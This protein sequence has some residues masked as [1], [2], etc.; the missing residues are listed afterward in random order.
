MKVKK[1]DTVVVITGKDAKKTGKVLVSMPKLNKIIVEGVNVQEKNRKARSAQETSQKIKKEGPIDASNVLVICPTC[2][3]AIRVAYA[4]VDGKKVRVCKK[5]G[6]VLDVKEEKKAVAK[7]ASKKAVKEEA[8]E[9]VAPAK[10]KKATKKST[11][12]AEV[13]VEEKVEEK[14]TTKKS[15]KKVAEGEEVKE[16]K[17]TSKKKTAK[18]DDAENA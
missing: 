12:K 9:E 1:N 16:V 17:K 7:K 3:K 6:A 11:K 13:A 14:K 15:T 4:I 8:T 18:K 2:D 5:C 10:E